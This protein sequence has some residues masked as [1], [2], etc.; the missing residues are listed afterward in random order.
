[1]FTYLLLSV[2]DILLAFTF[3]L[4]AVSPM[5]V[6]NGGGV[7]AVTAMMVLFRWHVSSRFTV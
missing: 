1:M 6:V 2:L 5:C 7:D 4:P 3:T